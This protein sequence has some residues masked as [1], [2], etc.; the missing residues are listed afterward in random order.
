MKTIGRAG[1]WGVLSGVVFGIIATSDPA[2]GAEYRFVARVPS[3][4]QAIWESVSGP[5]DLS[6]PSKEDIVLVL[7]NPTDVAHGFAIPHLHAV[8]REQ[9]IR[10]VD[11]MLP[12]ETV[13][14]YT[15]PISVTVEPGQVQRV[16][17][18]K[19]GFRARES[20]SETVVVFCPLHKTS[21]AGSVALVK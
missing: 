13:L 15:A 16:R 19:S 4:D 6:V 2:A 10:P 18:S 20:Y 14:Q 17:L 5:I 3:A 9:V 11:S 8:V 12:E 7:D 21:K 1:M